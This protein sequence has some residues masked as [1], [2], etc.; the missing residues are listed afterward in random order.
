MKKFFALIL[1]LLVILIALLNFVLPGTVANILEEQIIHAT[2]AQEV[3]VD[4]S[5]NPNAK[6]AL[7]EIEKIHGT[8]SKGHIGE[9]EFQNLTLDGTKIRLDVMELL[10][11]NK[12]LTAQERTRRILQHADKIEMRGVITEEKLRDFI[13][14]KDAH[15]ENPQVKITPEEATAQAR[16]K[17][18]GRTVDLD[19]AGTFIVSNGDVFFHMTRLDSNSILRRVNVDFFLNDVKVLDSSTLPIGL[20]FESVELRDGEAVLTATTSVQ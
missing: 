13:A 20:K 12:D 9:V 19:V 5:S 1:I 17:I 2:A 14:K 4:L 15:F 6:I 11:P 18:L 7:G 8:A 10:F 3:K 16:V